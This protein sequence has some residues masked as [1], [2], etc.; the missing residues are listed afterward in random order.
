MFLFCGQMEARDRVVRW[1]R[2]SIVYKPLDSDVRVAGATNSL[3]S[4]AEFGTEEHF[5]KV[6]STGGYPNGT[7]SDPHESLD[8][9]ADCF[10]H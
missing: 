1:T 3:G 10:R 5:G 7:Y 6:E 9:L 2:E 4:E 8:V